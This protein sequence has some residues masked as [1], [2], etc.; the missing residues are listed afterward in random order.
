[1]PADATG[2]RDKLIAAGERL[3]AS[4][5]VE[6]AQLRDIVQAAGQSNDSAIHYHFASR[7]GLLVAIC[8][9]HIAAMEPER[10]QLLDDLHARGATADIEAIV[11]ALVVP[12]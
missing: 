3:F 4:R 12:T 5:G 2:T 9:R 6:G 7:D 1:M 10:Q 11:T 8:E